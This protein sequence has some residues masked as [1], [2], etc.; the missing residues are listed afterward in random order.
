[1]VNVLQEIYTAYEL[2][3]A[4]WYNANSKKWY[5]PTDEWMTRKWNCDAQWDSGASMW[6]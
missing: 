1:M 6:L 4:L 5:Q 3:K 2:R